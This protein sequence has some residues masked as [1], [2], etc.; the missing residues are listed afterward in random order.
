M[1]R[2]SASGHDR[3]A[4]RGTSTKHRSPERGAKR[5]LERT[6]RACAVAADDELDFATRLRHE[7]VEVQAVSYDRGRG[8]GAWLSPDQGQAR[9]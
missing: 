3:A 5:L 9:R 2:K 8:R 4:G 1:G 6:V 7:G